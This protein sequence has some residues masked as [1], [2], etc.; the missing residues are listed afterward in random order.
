MAVDSNSDVDGYQA[1]AGFLG[2]PYVKE[3]ADAMFHFPLFFWFANRFDIRHQK[4]LIVGIR[5]LGG[6]FG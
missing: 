3:D 1:L 4:R 2:I 5:W 6:P